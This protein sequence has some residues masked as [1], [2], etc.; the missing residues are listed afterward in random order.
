MNYRIEGKFPLILSA[1]SIVKPSFSKITLQV[2]L[3]IANW[4]GG[5]AGL[6]RRSGEAASRGGSSSLLRD[7]PHPL[8][9]RR[10]ES[11]E[12][13]PENTG[14]PVRGPHPLVSVV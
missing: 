14:M 1:L 11:R 12:Q 2:W 8:S 4:S 9:P 13:D 3:V 10:V 7:P 5:D 6:V